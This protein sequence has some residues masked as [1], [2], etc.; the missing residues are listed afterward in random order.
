MRSTF[1][2]LNAGEINACLARMA[3]DFVM[4][5]AGAPEPMIGKAAWRSNLEYLLSAF[6]DFQVRVDDAFG[7]GD[8]VTCLMTMSGTH[9]GDFL[10]HAPS[11]RRVEFASHEVYR[12][13]DG[14]IAEEWILSD[15]F[16]LVSQIAD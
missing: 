7:A 16:S 12:V 5:L 15:L 9:R 11:G 3:D 8:R 10:G 1:D 2:L 6:P 4:N 13:T 14:V